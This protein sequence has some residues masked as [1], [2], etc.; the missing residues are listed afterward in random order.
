M[1]GLPP[2]QQLLAFKLVAELGSFTAAA[3]LLNLTQSAVS[4]QVSKLERR[5]GF[6]LLSRAAQNLSL[7]DAGERYYAAIAA[8]LDDLLRAIENL[9]DP[10]GPKRLIIQVESGLAAAWLSRRLHKFVKLRPAIHI[11][12]R[13]ASNLNFNDGVELAIK[14]GNGFWPH[15][16]A[17]LLMK[18]DYTPLCSPQLAKGTPGIHT[19]ADLRHQ[20]LLHDRQYRE[21]QLWLELA[22]E[23][24]IDGK[25]GH[26]VDDT[27]I[28]IDMAIAGQGVALCSPQLA[29]RAIDAGQLIAL[30]PDIRLETNEAYYLVT[31]KSTEISG[32]MK[33][34][35]GWLKE[36]AADTSIVGL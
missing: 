28:L 36:E 10:L 31:K 19:V 20:T 18:L 30:F 17:D 14:W 1:Q 8:P 26:V 34:F 3:K 21:W 7:T 9:G 35:I 15:Y 32:L 11:E 23:N 12:Q 22:G 6:R 24:T 29:Q 2:N 25:K 16:Q 13:R 27:N 4:H 33:L 5:L